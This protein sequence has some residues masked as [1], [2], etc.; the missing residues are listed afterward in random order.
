MSVVCCQSGN[1]SNAVGRRGI[2][3][4]QIVT[5]GDGCTWFCLAAGNHASDDSANFA[6]ACDCPR[7][8]TVCQH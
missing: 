6:E 5:T 4:T 7:V 8:I 2:D 3:C 1:V